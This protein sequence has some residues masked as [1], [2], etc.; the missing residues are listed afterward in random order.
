MEGQTV[1]SPQWRG[2][3]C[4]EDLSL[5]PSL[6]DEV[7]SALEAQR[8]AMT[9]AVAGG[10]AAS[11]IEHKCRDEAVKRWG[12]A[13]LMANPPSWE[14]YLLSRTSVGVPSSPMQLL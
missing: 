14:K 11:A 7:Q 13:V 10:G 8:E 1:Q 4:A 5:L 3:C 6:E 2:R 12:D 9:S